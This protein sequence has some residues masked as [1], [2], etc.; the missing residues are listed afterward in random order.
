MSFPVRRK[1]L[2]LLRYAYTRIVLVEIN[3][4]RSRTIR[5]GANTNTDGTFFVLR[6]QTVA[7]QKY[8]YVSTALFIAAALPP[9][10]RCAQHLEGRFFTPPSTA[11]NKA[12]VSRTS[13]VHYNDRG[14][15]CSRVSIT[16]Q[17]DI[18]YVFYIVVDEGTSDWAMA[19][20][21]CHHTMKEG[22]QL[23]QFPSI[24]GGVCTVEYSR[25]LSSQEKQ[26]RPCLTETDYSVL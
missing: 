5:V 14:S 12:L 4:N 16:M 19:P 2:P 17:G 18:C 26:S 6:R 25:H 1:T 21:W 10:S 13:A 24:F 20:R 11:R 23:Q 8:F 9:S 3:Q 15:D 7:C 22:R